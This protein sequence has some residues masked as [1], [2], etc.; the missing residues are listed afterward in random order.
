V[1]RP[2]LW[3]GAASRRIVDVIEAWAASGR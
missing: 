3:D 2:P 1:P